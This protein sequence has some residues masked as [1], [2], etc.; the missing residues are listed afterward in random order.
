MAGG[1]CTG[2]F[3]VIRFESTRLPELRFHASLI[4]DGIQRLQVACAYPRPAR[5][6]AMHQTRPGLSGQ[7]TSR[8]ASSQD[9]QGV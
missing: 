7:C 2:L 5:L 8:P 6:K 4:T 3:I 9:A 1:T